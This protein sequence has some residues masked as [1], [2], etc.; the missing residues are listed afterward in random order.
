MDDLFEFYEVNLFKEKISL[1]IK[2]WVEEFYLTIK[3]LNLW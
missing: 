3:N 2:F 1:N